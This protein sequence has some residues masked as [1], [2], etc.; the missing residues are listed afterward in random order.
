MAALSSARRADCVNGSFCS[1]LA[2][3]VLM[4]CG[5]TA[6]FEKL[7]FLTISGR[8]VCMSVLSQ[9]VILEKY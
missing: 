3:E 6:E 5:F 9:A 2:Q 7:A 1:Y 4:T 8:A